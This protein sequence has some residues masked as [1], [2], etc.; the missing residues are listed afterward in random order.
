MN[1]SM[2]NFHNVQL[3]SQLLDLQ[4]M[5]LIYIISTMD[6]FTLIH[7]TTTDSSFDKVH[8]QKLKPKI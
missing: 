3:S 6:I 7:D 8:Y 1:D 5:I 4:L 2:N